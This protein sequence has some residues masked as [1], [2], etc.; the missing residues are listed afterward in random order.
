VITVGLAALVA[1]IDSWGKLLGV[2][3]FY[4]VYQQVENAYLTPKIMESQLEIASSAILV[5]LIIGAELAGTAGALVAVP[6]AVLISAL[7]DE[8][9]VRSRAEVTTSG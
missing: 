1:A 3:I 5:A 4:L 2:L 9:V 8:Y 7:L 6:T